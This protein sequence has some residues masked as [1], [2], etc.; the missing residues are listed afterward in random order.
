MKNLFVLFICFIL[1]MPTTSFADDNLDLEGIEDSSVSEVYSDSSKDPLIYSNN[2][3]VIATPSM[4]PR[5]LDKDK[6]PLAMPS[7]SLFTLVMIA[8]LE[9]DWKQPL[10]IPIITEAAIISH[11]WVF[12][13]NVVNIISEIIYIAG[14][15]N[16]KALL[17]CFPE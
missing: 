5:F 11:I 4:L 10:P 9:G 2:V 15:I 17:P 13:L 8:L 14:P 7:S 3:I 16:V 12:V 6:I 1:I